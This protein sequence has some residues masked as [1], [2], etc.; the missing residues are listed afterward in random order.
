MTDRADS[1]LGRVV[2]RVALDSVTRG[3]DGTRAALRVAAFEKPIVES[4]LREVA[5]RL[6]DGSATDVIVK[7]GTTTAID[8]VPPDFLLAEGEQ[9]TAWRNVPGSG[10]S[11]LLF[12]WGQPPDAQGLS[13]VNRLDGAVLLTGQDEE[14]RF[15]LLALEAWLA[16][17]GEGRVPP[18]LV[19]YQRHIWRAVS[20]SEEESRSLRRLARYLVESAGKV[21]ASTVHTDEVIQEAAS[22]ALPSLGLFP[23]SGLFASESAVE[24]RIKKNVRV[25][26]LKQPNGA[27]LAEED[28]LARIDAAEL[29]AVSLERV[30]L[31]SDSAKTHM[32]NLVMEVG[33]RS[34]DARRALDLPLWLEIFEKRT[35]KVGLG[36]QIRDIVERVAPARLEEFDALLVEDG[37]D[38]S[39]QE[40]AERFLFA[41]PPTDAE[42]LADL[43]PKVLRRR[44]EKIAFPDSQVVLDPLRALLREL[45][46]FDDEEEGTVNVRVEGTLENGAWTRWLFAFLYG[47][48]LKQVQASA[49]L[50]LGLEVEASL[51]ACDAPELPDDDE[52]FDAS[53]AWAPIRVVVEMQG[54]AQRRFRWDP[55]AT[56]GQIAV[57]ALLCG[58]ETS[59]GEVHEGS[60]DG[61]LERFSDPRD[62]QRRG[63]EQPNGQFGAEL[64]TLRRKHFERFTEGVDAELIRA[65]LDEWEQIVNRARASLV[66]A[67]A[68]DP[69]LADVVLSDVIR[70]SDGRLMMLAS[71][72]LRLRW[73]ARHYAEVTAW[74]AKALNECLKLNS[75]NSDLFFDTLERVS[76]HGTPAMIVGPNQTVAIPMRE[77]AGHEEY[78]PVRQGGNESRDWLA[79]VDETA[80]EE[81]VRVITDYLVTYPH[82]MDGLAVLLL[83]RNGDPVLPV[84]VAKRMRAKNP[85][86]RLDLVVLAPRE[87]HHGIIQAFDFEFADSDVAEER[88]LPDVQLVL[89]PWNSD[90]DVDFSGLEDSI[91]IALAPALFGTQTSLN[92]STR[93]PSATLAGRYDPW[94][95]PAAH[96]LA[97]SSEN[98]VRELLPSS[99]DEVLE[100][101]STLCVRYDRRSAVAREAEGNTDYFEMQIQFDQHQDLFV[102]LHRVAHWVVTLDAF[103]GRDQIDH[104]RDR[105]DVILVK[106][107]VGKNEAYTLIVSS[108]TGRQ[109]VVRRL[110]RRLIDIGV[111]EPDEAEATASRFYSV[112][113]N[114]VPGAV[115]R[116]LGIG[117]TINEIVGLVA[118]RYVIAQHVPV[119]HDQSCLVV[120]LSFDEQQRW[121]GR[122][123][124]TRADLGRFALTLVEDGS[125]KL[126]ILVAESKFRQAYDHGSA[127]E[128]LNRTTDLCRV[129]FAS[130]EDATD[131]H[132][133]WLQELASAIEQTSQEALPGSELPS[134][135]HV[136]PVRPDLVERVIEELRSG[137]VVLNSVKGVAVAIAAGQEDPAPGPRALGS[138]TLVRLNRP[139]LQRVIALLRAQTDPALIPD[140]DVIETEVPQSRALT[141][142]IDAQLDTE[143]TL[144]SAREVNVPGERPDE[145]GNSAPRVEDESGEL[146]SSQEG[147][148]SDELRHRYNEV[149]SVFSLHNVQVGPPEAGDAWQE[150]PGFYVLRFVPRPGVTV[151]KVVNRREEIFLAL[152]LPAGY[153]IRTRSDRGAVVF[154]IPKVEGEK[155]GVPA[156][157]L[158]QMCPV[159]G[160]DL[161]APVGADIAGTPVEIHFSSPDSP[162]LLVAGTTGSGKSVALD[163]I[164]KGLLRYDASS[165]RLRLVDPKGT[166]LVDFEDDPHVDGSIGMDADDAIEILEAAVQEMEDRYRA[167]KA[168]RARKLVEYNS[169]VDA[170]ERKPWIVI[171][172]DEYADLTSDPDD[173]RAIED[174]LRRLTQ[175]A[176][177][178]GIHVIAATQRPSADVI[179]TTIRSNFPAQ[180]ALR[181]KTATDS[182]IVLDETGAES[183]AGRGDALL[184]TAQGT[185][186]IQVAY[187]NS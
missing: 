161:I 134:R 21:A 34:E 125:V 85:K 137:N 17:G 148:G 14:A 126:D 165:V 109:L 92:A 103:I 57:A 157:A 33:E 78:A 167:M 96:N 145:G 25:A 153:S 102:A 144:P 176:R 163:T 87:T 71:H 106:P 104:L 2:A 131:D 164:L 117:T 77:S 140:T 184:H 43:L 29:T 22:S 82:K 73:L 173:K 149:L 110:R 179:S 158:W 152:G 183:L 100:T 53:D 81:M 168:V 65:Y 26:G 20:D 156:K 15:G 122:G 42:T 49:G 101:W 58:F 39:D 18:A 3:S 155:Y 138:H 111:V 115:L 76:P 41:E 174:L 166:E 141:S 56:P 11:V 62:W 123:A 38:H 154:E 132:K 142:T 55:F 171:V 185:V 36:R 24:A 135:K 114:V 9:L 72:P 69:D 118:T 75:E 27:L 70:L 108:Q 51:L 61:F 86:L 10:A 129:A 68:P 160:S 130:G 143:G 182:R 178:A 5:Q 88:F 162:H 19:A 98:V 83:D 6:T 93:D 59:P 45:T 172:L 16:A 8:G 95:H 97:E 54:G 37:L 94:T 159:N 105:P 80:I 113:R 74:I 150:G 170:G 4:A 30:A 121:F 120:W 89:K 13:A 60:F 90:R 181:V 52:P 66:P 151:D 12:D 124:K 79:A 50:R 187:D 116:S 169:R 107:G 46:Y 177:A 40:A 91:D 175:K 31:S 128:Q 32:R 84:R 112:G 47:R 180:L 67:N 35:T 99:P 48:S 44:V 1:T 136:G 133:F 139:E 28:L 146:S 119:P 186:R 23:D 147:L 63:A 127:E 7:V 64:F